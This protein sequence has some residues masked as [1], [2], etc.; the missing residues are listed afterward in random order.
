MIVFL[1]ILRAMPCYFA[2]KLDEQIITVTWR[3]VFP[4]EEEVYNMSAILLYN[5]AIISLF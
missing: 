1:L 2:M 5:L 3:H 4:T